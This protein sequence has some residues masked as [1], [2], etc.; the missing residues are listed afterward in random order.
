MNKKYDYAVI[1]LFF[2]TMLL[3]PTVMITF[4]LHGWDGFIFVISWAI[5]LCI[6]LVTAPKFMTYDEQPRRS[7]KQA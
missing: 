4:Q 5:G 1:T 7:D 3:L 6:F 2:I